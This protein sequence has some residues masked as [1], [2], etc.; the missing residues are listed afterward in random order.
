[1]EGGARWRLIKAAEKPYLRYSREAFKL[2]QPVS[3]LQKCMGGS[4]VRVSGYEPALIHVMS[5]QT[6]AETQLHL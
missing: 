3:V 4:V 6:R 2:L 1:M 5:T